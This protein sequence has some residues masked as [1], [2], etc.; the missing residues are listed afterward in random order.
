MANYWVQAWS[1]SDF[2]GALGA[3]ATGTNGNNVVGSSS[4]LSAT[5]TRT[6]FLI[7]DDDANLDDMYLETG[8][9]NSLAGPLT[10]DGT[11]YPAGSSVEAE[12][13]LITD[14]LP[15]IQLVVGRIGDG[16]SNSGENLLVFSIGSHHPVPG[17]TYTFADNGDDAQVPYNTICFA[18]GTRIETDQGQ[19]PV[20]DIAPGTNVRNMDGDF[21]P[22]R[23]A[24]RR[25][26]SSAEL[27]M[28]PHLSPVRIRKNALGNNRPLHDLVVSPQHRIFLSDWRAELLFG[29]QDFLVP[30][31]A[32]CNDTTIRR[33][34]PTEGVTYHHLLFDRHEVIRANG[35]WAESLFPGPNALSTLNPAQLTE[36]FEVF[37]ALGDGSSPEL[38]AQKTLN[39]WEY[40]VLGN[41]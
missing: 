16:T 23:W 35:Q 38:A 10:I 31:I 17:Q 24:G 36:L 32:L 7:S 25:H 8:A 19:M 37:P 13:Y 18:S 15:A 30:A 33:D 20:E 34:S 29:D 41:Y 5:A 1:L 26:F 6:T 14:D 12:Y 40:R 9:V 21:V 22:V 27:A 2:S 39:P 28:H 11:T 3:D 4:T